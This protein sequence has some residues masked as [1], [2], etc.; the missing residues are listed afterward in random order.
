[1][2]KI[3]EHLKAEWIRYGFET[4]VVIV[5]ILIAFYLSN[6]AENQREWRKE[7]AILQEIKS[8]LEVSLK[9]LN[10]DKM[11][12]DSAYNSTARVVDFLK[13]TENVSEGMASDFANLISFS[14]FFP[15]TGGYES[16]KS[17]G[18]E[19]IS[20]DSLKLMITNVY[21]LGIKRIKS[22][23]SIR[24]AKLLLFPFFKEN[25]SLIHK[26]D[27]KKSDGEISYDGNISN[28]FLAYPIDYSRLQKSSEFN[29]LLHQS[30]IE[31][32]YFVRDYKRLQIDII[33]LIKMINRNIN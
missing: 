13:N 1:M 19:I 6:W 30:I 31:R 20:S 23:E 10:E 21:E 9:D 26:E 2:N 28:E 7:V 29:I 14:F 3:F 17:A 11:I 24:N 12:M 4:L 33:N 8:D 32:S 25:F 5:G 16:L 15:Q 18:L 22:K 27:V